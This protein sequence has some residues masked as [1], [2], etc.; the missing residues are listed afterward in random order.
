MSAETDLTLKEVVTMATDPCVACEGTH[1]LAVLTKW[2]KFKGLNRTRIY[3]SVLKPVVFNRR[4]IL[5]QGVLREL[6]FEVHL[7]D[8]LHCLLT[9]QAPSW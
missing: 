9:C 7:F 5:D 3:K 1:T 2:I 4:N 6:G 8:K